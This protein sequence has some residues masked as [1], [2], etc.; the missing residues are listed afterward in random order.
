LSFKACFCRGGKVMPEK[1][2]A[3]LCLKHFA[4]KV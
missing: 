3:K 2:A 4:E 1:V